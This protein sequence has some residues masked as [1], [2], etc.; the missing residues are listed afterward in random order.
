M[1]TTTSSNTNPVSF[2]GDK[3]VRRLDEF[4]DL[5]QA[6]RD[7][8]LLTGRMFCAQLFDFDARR[9]LRENNGTDRPQSVPTRMRLV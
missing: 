4:P 9:G 5:V 8:D 7:G 3:I 6:L 1:I 2:H